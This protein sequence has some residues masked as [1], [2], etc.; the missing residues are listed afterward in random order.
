MSEVAALEP[1]GDFHSALHFRDLYLRDEIVYDEFY[2]P[3]CGVPLDDVLIYKPADFEMGKSPHFATKR[4]GAKHLTGCD[5]NPS[6]YQH[7]TQKNPAQSHVQK[8]QFSLPTQFAEYVDRPA[9]PRAPKSFQISSA[10]EVLRR[11]QAA[12]RAYSVARYKV[13][14]VQSLAEAHLS[15]LAHAYEQKKQSGWSEMQCQRWIRDELQAP[16]DLRGYSTTYR[17]AL[18][19]LY[20]PIPKYPRVFYGRNARVMSTENGY[21]VVSERAGKLE[22]DQFELPFVITV[23]LTGM[24]T[25][26][27]RGARAAL[28][29]QLER[30]VKEDAYVRWYAYGCATLAG[31]RFELRFDATNIGDLYVKVLKGSNSTSST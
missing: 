29:R 15:V 31:N 8:R 14:L 5:G 28:L 4:N 6:D 12:G 16:L 27:L 1:L 20:F 7:P 26:E 30:A 13:S 19:D 25:G 18:H 22:A 9:K 3:F 2:C 10:E 11:R 21:V 17:G 24:D 23:S